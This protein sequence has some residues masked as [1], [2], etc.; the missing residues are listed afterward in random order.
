MYG[1]TTIYLSGTPLIFRFFILVILGH[2]QCCSACLCTYNFAQHR[3][4]TF[5]SF[6][7]SAGYYDYLLNIFLNDRWKLCL[8]LLLFIYSLKDFHIFMDYLYLFLHEM[9]VN[10][11]CNKCGLSRVLSVISAK[12]RVWGEWPPFTNGCVIRSCSRTNYPCLCFLF[13]IIF[14]RIC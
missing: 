12:P 11:C 13:S 3:A 10:I 2:K 1:Y 7:S 14:C 8:L 5:C 4:A 9:Y 6:P